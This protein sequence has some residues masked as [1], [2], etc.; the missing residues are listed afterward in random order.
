M[1]FDHGTDDFP[2]KKNNYFTLSLPSRFS[3]A[4]PKTAC[5]EPT[6]PLPAAG[7]WDI[8]KKRYSSFNTPDDELN[9]IKE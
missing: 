1:C 6:T 8:F 5:Y 2:G 4:V 9:E 3:R 7:S